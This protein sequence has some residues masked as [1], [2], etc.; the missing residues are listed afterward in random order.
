M[1]A[2]PR[3]LF[4]H[5]PVTRDGTR[6]QIS[7]RQMLETAGQYFELSAESVRRVLDGGVPA[8]VVAMPVPVTIAGKLAGLPRRARPVSGAHSLMLAVIRRAA[9]GGCSKEE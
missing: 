7:S 2:D 1:S 6:Q 8:A 3:F 9:D 5:G 4:P